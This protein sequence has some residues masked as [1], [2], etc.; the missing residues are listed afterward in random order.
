MKHDLES[1]RGTLWKAFEE[2]AEQPEVSYGD[3]YGKAKALGALGTPL[4]AIELHFATNNA[5]KPAPLK[6]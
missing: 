2:V 3:A 4:A 6:S 5:S 1:L